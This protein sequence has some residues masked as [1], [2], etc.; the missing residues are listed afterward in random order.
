MNMAKKKPKR[1]ILS[2]IVPTELHEKLSAIAREA[3]K[4]VEHIAE[5]MLAAIVEDDEAAHGQSG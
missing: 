1:K 5:S 4:D 2:L 3:G